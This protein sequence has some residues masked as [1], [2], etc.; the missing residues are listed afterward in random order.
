M[1]IKAPFGTTQGDLLRLGNVNKH[2]Y[3]CDQHGLHHDTV[4]TTES[5]DSASCRLLDSSSIHLLDAKQ[6]FGGD[7]LGDGPGSIQKEHKIPTNC[8]SLNEYCCAEDDG[9]CDPPP[10]VQ[11]SGDH[12]K[13]CGNEIPCG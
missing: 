9:C 13:A 10:F 4:C 11:S 8:A 6:R 2:K 3:F 1:W 12:S 5:C 7:T